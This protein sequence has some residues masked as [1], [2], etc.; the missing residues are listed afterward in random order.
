MN[1]RGGSNAGATVEARGD[2][3]LLLAVQGDLATPAL[4]SVKGALA[5]VDHA[6][7]STA[8]KLAAAAPPAPY[9]AGV[10]VVLLERTRAFVAHSG[11]G[12]CYLER[13]GKLEAIAAGAY[14]LAPGESILAASHATLAVGQAFLG[15]VPAAPDDAFRN[16]GLDAALETALASTGFVAVAAARA[17]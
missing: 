2:L 5:R 12:R 17:V 3:V 11:G 8:A 10:A 6:D 14:E 4:E 15:D 13:D 7:A 9:C 1:V 16:D